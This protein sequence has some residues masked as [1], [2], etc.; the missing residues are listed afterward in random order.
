MKKVDF[1][2]VLLGMYA[3]VERKLSR[4]EVMPGN[5]G[6]E[7]RLEICHQKAGALEMIKEVLTRINE[8]TQ[9]DNE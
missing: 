2:E 6:N 9:D 4:G 8:L 1:E 7:R 3:D 5:G